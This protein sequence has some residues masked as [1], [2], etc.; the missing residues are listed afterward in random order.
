[1]PDLPLKQSLRE[2][3]AYLLGNRSWILIERETGEGV[4]DGYSI[5]ETS[6]GIMQVIEH[7]E[8]QRQVTAMMLADGA[9]VFP[10]MQ[11]VIEKHGRGALPWD[12]PTKRGGK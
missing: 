1:M 9:E 5:Y 4:P 6:Q 11:A 2:Q 8:T 7:N 10:S 3:Y 12:D